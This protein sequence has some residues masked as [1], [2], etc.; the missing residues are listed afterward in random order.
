MKKYLL[1]FIILSALCFNVYGQ[2]RTQRQ[3]D[4]T[5]YTEFA[6]N[7]T[8]TLHETAR[9]KKRLQIAVSSFRAP[10]TAG[11]TSVAPQFTIGWTG[12]AET[13][14]EVVWQV[15]VLYRQLNED[16][17]STS[18]DDTVSVKASPSGTA[19]GLVL[20][21]FNLPVLHADDAGIIIRLKRLA[22][23]VDDDLDGVSYLI[24]G[25]IDYTSNKLGTDY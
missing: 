15:E 10:G 2:E 17:S 7:G 9:V 6:D 14:G 24:G 22:T 19:N 11:A 5:N 16:W 21:S 4:G 23:D 18:V 20:T 13:T 8:I 25:A 3:G 1:S 12:G